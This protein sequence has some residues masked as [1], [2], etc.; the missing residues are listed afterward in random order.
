VDALA[1]EIRGLVEAT[2]LLRGSRQ[3]DRGD[4]LQD[5]ALRRRPAERELQT[6]GLVDGASV[7]ALDP[8]RNPKRETAGARRAGHLDPC[9]AGIALPRRKRARIQGDE[10][11]R[12]PPRPGEP[13]GNHEGDEAMRAAEQRRGQS[14]RAGRDCRGKTVNRYEERRGETRAECTDKQVRPAQ[15]GGVHRSTSS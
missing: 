14:E 4:D 13:E 10:P 2:G 5:R 1:S 9:E 12:S 15:S 3:L 11:R 8:N 6:S 7:E